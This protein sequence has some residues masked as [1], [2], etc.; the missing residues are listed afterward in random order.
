MGEDEKA[1]TDRE[2]NGLD[3]GGDHNPALAFLLH[4]AIWQWH[5]GVE[6][7]KR[8]AKNLSSPNPTCAL[9]LHC[10]EN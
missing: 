9:E 7:Y 1:K 4:L 2:V 8:M 6:Q 10:H 3:F 5:A